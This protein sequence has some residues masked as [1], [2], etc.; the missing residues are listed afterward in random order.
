[1]TLRRLTPLIAM[2]LPLGGCGPDAGV[3][4]VTAS[5][6]EA[7]NRAAAT[8]DAQSAQARQVD[9]ALNPAAQAARDR[10]AAAQSD[11]P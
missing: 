7:L 4:G 2:L 3:G 11:A 8:L 6:A 1:M 5:E 10:R 9:G